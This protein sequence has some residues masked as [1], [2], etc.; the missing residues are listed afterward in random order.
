VTSNDGVTSNHG[1]PSGYTR[2]GVL[3]ASAALGVAAIGA[4]P[5]SAAAAE[6]RRAGSQPQVLAGDSAHDDTGT[7]ASQ[8]ASA[9]DEAALWG[10]SASGKGIGVR[11]SGHAGVLGEGTH[12]GVAGDGHV[13][14]HGTTSIALDRQEGVGVWAE[15]Q[16][17]GGV[18]LRADGPSVFNGRADFAGVTTFSRSGVVT[19]PRG[20]LSVTT[21]GVALTPATIILATPQNRARD[22]HVHAVETDPRA[23]SFTCYLTGKAPADVRI[24]WIAIG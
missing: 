9:V 1:Q 12:T 8:A 24:G 19:V 15:S 23:G 13:G 5:A 16:T 20:R 4:V 3:G 22:V 21:T 10:A 17:P 6:R 2:R 14:V 18:A 7:R 11:G